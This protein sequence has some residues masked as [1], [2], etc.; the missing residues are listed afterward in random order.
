[1]AARVSRPPNLIPVRCHDIGSNPTPRRHDDAGPFCVQATSA[2]AVPPV[3]ND[4]ITSIDGSIGRRTSADPGRR[5]DGVRRW[6]AARDNSNK[7]NVP[8]LLGLSKT[9]PYFHNSSAASFEE[10]VDDD[11]QF[12]NRVK[13]TNAVPP[14]ITATNGRD[15]DCQPTAEE[16]APPLAYLRKPWPKWIA[17]PE[18]RSRDRDS[19]SGRA[20]A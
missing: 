4:E 11:I 18:E 7:F 6:R 5:A 3:T 15:C 9:A 8:G 19:D 12:F 14:H 16:R 20:A 2:V 17:F 13:A 1:M 10:M